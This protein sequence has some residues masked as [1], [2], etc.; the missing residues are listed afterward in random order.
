MYARYLLRSL[1]STVLLFASTE[2]AAQTLR[3]EQQVDLGYSDTVMALAV[4]RGRVFTAAYGFDDDNSLWGVRVFER[5]GTPLWHETLS[6]PRCCQADLPFAMPMALDAAGDHL[7]VVGSLDGFA[8][9]L[10][11]AMTGAVRWC[12]RVPPGMAQAVVLTNTRVY[13]G[14][15]VGGH[16]IVRAY[17][18]AGT[19]LWQTP[20]ETTADAVQSLHLHKNVLFAVRRSGL[21]QALRVA[22]G[23]KVW[24]VPG[25]PK[26]VINAAALADGRLVMVGGQKSQWYVQALS[27]QDGHTLWSQRHKGDAGIEFAT[28]LAVGDNIYVGGGFLTGYTRTVVRAYAG[29]DGAVLWEALAPEFT[30]GHEGE[31][32]VTSLA[33]DTTQERLYVASQMLDQAQYMAWPDLFVRIYDTTNG[34]PQAAL[35]VDGTAHLWDGALALATKGNHLYV[36]GVVNSALFYT[37][38]A[39]LLVQAYHTTPAPRVAARR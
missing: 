19:L 37:G 23:R 25:L 7:A 5:T 10:Y 21:V 1:M 12:D 15:S 9:R 16:A 27:S 14:G 34:M 8:V 6:V 20:V 13:A 32:I 3:W 30:D 4:H 2:L 11:D 26:T 31:N 24:E 39:D 38:M 28:T 33:V 22:N 36:A 29:E 35:Q 17:N 18:L